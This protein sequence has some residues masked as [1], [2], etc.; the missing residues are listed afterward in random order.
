MDYSG[1]DREEEVFDIIRRPEGGAEDGGSE[2]LNDFGDGMEVEQRDEA[3]TSIDC[4]DDSQNVGPA[5]TKSG[6]VY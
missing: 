1:R 2:F 6:K 5:L 3:Q 4:D